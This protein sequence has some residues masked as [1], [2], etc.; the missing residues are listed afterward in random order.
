MPNF[1][2]ALKKLA[3]DPSDPN[4][5]EFEVIQRKK[6]SLCVT[7]KPNEKVYRCNGKKNACKPAC[8]LSMNLEGLTFPQAKAIETEL[9]DLL[10]KHEF[11]LR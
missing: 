1:V 4:E 2:E 9:R 8:N 3:L 5:P 11:E 10:K 6:Y 7:D